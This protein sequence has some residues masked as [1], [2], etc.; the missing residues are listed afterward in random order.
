V[1][2]QSENDFG[3]PHA[4][5][6][7]AIA[8]L[9]DAEFHTGTWPYVGVDYGNARVSDRQVRVLFVAMERNGTYNLADEPTFARTQ[10]NFRYSAV[11][12][13]NAHMGGTSQL[14]QAPNRA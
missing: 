7:S 14:K 1:P 8:R 9:H 6:C 10:E 4:G 12:H 11:V 2:C 13:H 5:E 3:C